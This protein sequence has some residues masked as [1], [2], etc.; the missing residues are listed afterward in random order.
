MT[1]K[2][3]IQYFLA[4]AAYAAL[5][6][7]FVFM[8]IEITNSI[9]WQPYDLLYRFFKWVEQYIILVLLVLGLLGLERDYLP[10]YGPA[11]LVFRRGHCRFRKA[12]Q[13]RQRAYSAARWH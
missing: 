10:L 13:S 4:L 9:T 7:F 5:L 6:F 8:G 11:H 1:R 2:M 3:L 12:G